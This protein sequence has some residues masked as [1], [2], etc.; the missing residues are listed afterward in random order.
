MEKIAILTIS[1]GNYIKLVDNLIST[2]NI[3]FLPSYEKTIF[4]FSDSNII[5]NCNNVIPILHLPWP[6]STLLRFYYFNKINNILKT[7][8][9]IYY[10]DCDMIVY[11]LVDNE[12][13]PTDNE[14]VAVEHYW[15][16]N[17]DNLYERE[18]PKSTAYVDTKNLSNF[19]YC[20]CCFFGAKSNI[21]LKMSSILEQNINIDLKNNIIAKWHDESH[22][23][24]Y[25]T[26]HPKKILHNGYAHPANIILNENKNKIKFIHKNANSS[27][28]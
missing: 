26:S 10:I 22:F 24:K 9:Y 27:G 18:N 15:E 14:I 6:L 11:D 3:N 20:Q 28:I 12:I 4:V 2:I 5:N 21:F 16:Y 1:T 13:I 17:S 7:F 25:I 23:N 8:D 19:T